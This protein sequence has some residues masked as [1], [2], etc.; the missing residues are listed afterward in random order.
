MLLHALALFGAFG[1]GVEQSDDAIG[2]AHRG[3]FRIGDDHRDVGEAHRERRAALD[4]GGAV[5][6]DPVE[7]LAQFVD[8]ARTPSSVKASLS[9]VCDAGSR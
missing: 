3:D 6:D 9:R 4:A 2:I 7:F 5:A 1:L 8:D